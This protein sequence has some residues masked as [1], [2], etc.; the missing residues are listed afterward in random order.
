MLTCSQIAVPE[1]SKQALCPFKD[2]NLSICVCLQGFFC[3]QNDW[4]NKRGQKLGSPSAKV[5]PCKEFAAQQSIMNR[6]T[7]Y[8]SLLTKKSKKVYPYRYSIM[9]VPIPAT[10]ATL[11][12]GQRPF[13]NSLCCFTKI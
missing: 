5:L 8:Y 7:K 9:V 6:S 2:I 10:V 3:A 13:Q 12:C 1:N 4:T 11:T